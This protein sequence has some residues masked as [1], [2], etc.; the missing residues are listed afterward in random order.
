VDNLSAIAQQRLLEQTRH[1]WS[2]VPFDSSFDSEQKT[3]VAVDS[4]EIV[5]FLDGEVRDERIAELL[6]GLAW[7]EPGGW[8]GQ[9]QAE[10]LPFVYTALKPLFTPR[11]VIKWLKDHDRLKGEVP[12]LPIP[13]AL[14]SL[15]TAGRIQQAV[16]RAQERARA[17]GLPTPFLQRGASFGRTVDAKF[18]RRLL[19]ALII[20]VHA[21][22]VGACLK[23]TYSDS[24]EKNSHAA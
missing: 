20:P 3:T 17:S 7:V 5:A 12:D 18:G 23:Q 6:L 16:Q 22:V 10:P 1:G 14:P 2:E 24:D 11:S 19:A 8:S 15:L 9:R 4:G 21:S 13:P